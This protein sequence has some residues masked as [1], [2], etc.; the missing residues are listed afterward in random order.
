MS[1]QTTTDVAGTE[2][3]RYVVSNS[4]FAREV[5]DV[6]V[7]LEL[8]SGTYFSVSNVA[9]EIWKAVQGGNDLAGVTAAVVESFDVDPERAATDVSQFLDDAVSRGLVELR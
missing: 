1:E 5:G 4:V 7:L 3:T 9:A 8:G 2:S 6:V